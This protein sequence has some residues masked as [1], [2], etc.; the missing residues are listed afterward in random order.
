MVPGITSLRNSFSRSASPSLRHTSNAGRIVLKFVARMVSGLRAHYQ[1]MPFWMVV[2]SSG[3]SPP[4]L[5]YGLGGAF[6]VDFDHAQ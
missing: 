4:P 6:S 5:L 2:R 1:L 3:L